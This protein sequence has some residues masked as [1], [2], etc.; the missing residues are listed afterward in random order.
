MK[1]R[2]LLHTNLNENC[3]LEL[4]P[5]RYLENEIKR[6][7]MKG[8]I[9]LVATK[10]LFARSGTASPDNSYCYKHWPP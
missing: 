1:K 9:N 3:L 7:K 8:I 6:N 10:K 2:G 5:I 4:V